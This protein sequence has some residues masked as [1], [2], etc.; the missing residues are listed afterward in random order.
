VRYYER[1]LERMGPD[2]RSFAR[3]FMVPGMFHCRGG[4]GVDRFD[5]LAALIA[6]VERAEAPA[7]IVASRVENGRIVRTRP[8]CPYPEVAR[9]RG[10]GSTDTAENFACEAPKR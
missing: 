4:L 1:V 5:G 2:T 8:L 6:W 3:L 10:K 9:Y 7:Q